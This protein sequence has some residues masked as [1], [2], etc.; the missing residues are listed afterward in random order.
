MKAI[1]FDAGNTLVWLDHDFIL[2][3]LRGHGVER[4]MTELLEAEHG[5]K[6]LLDELVRA[7]SAGDDAARGKAFFAEIF[8]R[9]GVP[10]DAFAPL[11]Q[12]LLARHEER[13]LWGVVRERTAETLEALRARGYRLGVISNADGRVEPLLEAVGLR[14][15]FE[16]VI[17]SGKVGVEKPDPRIFRLGCERLGIEPGH[18]AYVGD[19]YEIDVVGARSAGMRPLLVDPLDRFAGYAVERVRGIHELLDLFPA[20]A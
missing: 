16:F 10:A 5:A 1:L 12:R 6:L 11:A 7:G 18:V 14:R 19:I 2:E 8:R 9:L 13:N 15:H 17:D 4:S 3:L 20:A